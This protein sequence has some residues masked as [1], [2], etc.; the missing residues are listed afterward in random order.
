MIKANGTYAV[1]R[2]YYPL[3]KGKELCESEEGFILPSQY[4]PQQIGSLSSHLNQHNDLV[5]ATPDK[6]TRFLKRNRDGKGSQELT[7]VQKCLNE[8]ENW[9]RTE[10]KK[11][12][13][14]SWCL[15][16]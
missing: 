9:L 10:K 16:I 12:V 5:H 1:N 8:S 2:I 7:I 6:D 13:S 11:R 3:S 4:R 15:P 14:F